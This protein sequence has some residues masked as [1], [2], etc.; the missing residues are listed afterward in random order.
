MRYARFCRGDVVWQGALTRTHIG[1]SFWRNVRYRDPVEECYMDYTQMFQGKRIT[2]MGLGLL[3]RGVG[4]AQFLAECG[5]Q[6][7]VTDKKTEEQLKE[8]VNSLRGYNNI[9]FFLGDHR[10]SDFTEADMVVKAAGVPLDS[11]YIKAARDAGVPVEMSTSLFAQLTPATIVGV[12]GTRG[13]SSV[14]HLCADVLTA[15]GYNVF[16][17]GNVKGVSTLA[18]LPESHADEVAVLE[19]DSWQLQ[20]F[21]DAGISPHVAV[22]TSFFADHLD[23]YADD[24]SDA[25]SV[26]EGM[27]RYL[28]DKA[29]IFVNQP[30]HDYLVI[31]E[32]AAPS[33]YQY[34]H[35]MRAHTVIAETDNVPA[36]WDIQVPGDHNRANIACVIE[37]ARIFDVAA[38]TVQREVEAFGGVEGRLQW[39]DTIDGVD[40]YNDTTATTPDATMA[41]LR[42]LHPKPETRD[43][44]PRSASPRGTQGSRSKHIVLI[45]GGADKHLDLKDLPQ[46][47]NETCRHIVLLAGSGTERL[48]QHLSHNRYTEVS[49]MDEAVTRAFRAAD[50]GD[51]VVLSP[52]FSSFNLFANEFDRGSQ[53]ADAVRRI[54]DH[55]S[56]SS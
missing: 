19:L 12:T 3:G 48:K 50:A 33:L 39:I 42:A 15:A 17:G 20:G 10:I 27:E 24:A 52:A 30:R 35:A 31:S 18:H 43:P 41:A 23:Y 5:A 2:L 16:L 40:V 44:T 34:E 13:K 29:N 28:R 6:V 14:T 45:A 49:T 47:I 4:D 8:S 7:I 46:V 54:A 56:T 11:P 1:I 37:V 32:Q 51:V 53:F 21:G 9:S 55:N 22:F 26:K 38:E 25:G 36:T